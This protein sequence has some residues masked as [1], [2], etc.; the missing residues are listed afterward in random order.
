MSFT[1]VSSKLAIIHV[2]KQPT[3]RQ[4][5][6]EIALFYSSSTMKQWTWLDA[7]SI[8]IGWQ[9]KI[10]WHRIA[11]D[12]FLITLP[13]CQRVSMWVVCKY[14]NQIIEHMHDIAELC[15]FMGNFYQFY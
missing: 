3:A 8:R 5:D 1:S 11:D 4:V 7:F 6:A 10:V 15:K 9:T 13:V 14:W 2:N 12:Q